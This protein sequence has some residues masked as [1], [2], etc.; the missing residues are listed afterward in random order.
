[1]SASSLMS[2][3]KI[4]LSLDPVAINELFH[5]QALTLPL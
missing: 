5:A 3:T 2:Q 1:M 4:L